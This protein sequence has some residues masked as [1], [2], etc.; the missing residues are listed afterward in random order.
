MTDENVKTDRL[1][2]KMIHDLRETNFTEKDMME[3]FLNPDMEDEKNR[4]TVTPIGRTDDIDSQCRNEFF[5]EIFEDENGVI[6]DLRLYTREPT[7]EE[8][9]EISKYWVEL[10]ITFSKP[11]KP[12][13]II[14][15]IIK[16]LFYYKIQ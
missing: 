10:K 4:K 3:F 16:H 8:L 7:P 6:I 12:I 9:I 15:N 2:Q 1:I 14:K 11:V 13:F 5:E